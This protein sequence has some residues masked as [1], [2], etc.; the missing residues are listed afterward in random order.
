[1]EMLKLEDFGEANVVSQEQQL[2]IV[3]LLKIVENFEALG[4]IGMGAIAMP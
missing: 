2:R 3:N 1:M 4:E